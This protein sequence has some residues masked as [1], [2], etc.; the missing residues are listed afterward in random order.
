[1]C[2]RLG[3]ICEILQGVE[4]FGIKGV[5]GEV[6]GKEDIKEVRTRGLGRLWWMGTMLG[7]LDAIPPLP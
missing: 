7:H 1:M 4:I 2:E 5:K 3:D 6:E